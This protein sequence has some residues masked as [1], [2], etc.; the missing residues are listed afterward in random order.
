M[1][2]KQKEKDSNTTLY[3]NFDDYEDQFTYLA[4][5]YPFAHTFLFILV[6]N[7]NLNNDFNL[8]EKELIE[9]FGIK[10]QIIH[11]SLNILEELGYIEKIENDN[12]NI[13]H[14]NEKVFKKVKGK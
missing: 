13:Y 14:V 6:D 9:H 2:E 3:A 1:T 7:M 5:K 4:F 10:E 8:K 12:S 11:E